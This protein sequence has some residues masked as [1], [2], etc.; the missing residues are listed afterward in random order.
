MFYFNSARF[1]NIITTLAKHSRT[2]VRK[3]CDDDKRRFPTGYESP[4]SSKINRLQVEH[5]LKQLDTFENERKAYM[6]NLKQQNPL[7]YDFFELLTE[8]EALDHERTTLMTELQK[9][10]QTSNQYY[11][12]HCKEPVLTELKPFLL[13]QQETLSNKN[14]DDSLKLKQTIIKDLAQIDALDKKKSD[15]EQ[16]VCFFSKRRPYQG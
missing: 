16:E 2:N 3:L 10:E 5:D 12:R 14:D 13:Q 8:G 4:V 7:Q 9:Y 15:Y 11:Y 6:S 1:F